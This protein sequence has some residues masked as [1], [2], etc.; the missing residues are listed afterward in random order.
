MDGPAP[1]V[2]A[3]EYEAAEHQLAHLEVFEED[4]SGGEG[5]PPPRAGRAAGDPPPPS[6]L[7]RCLATSPRAVVGGRLELLPT[8]R[9]HIVAHGCLSGPLVIWKRMLASGALN[10]RL[11]FTP[12][13]WKCEPSSLLP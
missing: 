4:A 1:F 12:C 8:A 2:F 7:G 11:S 3:V 6:E 9:A 5:F 13:R 10:W